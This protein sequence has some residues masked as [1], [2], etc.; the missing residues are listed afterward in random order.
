MNNIKE[1]LQFKLLRELKQLLVER[2]KGFA[3]LF[4]DQNFQK[5]RKGN[6]VSNQTIFYWEK[7]PWN[8]IDLRL[9]SS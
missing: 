2:E 7:I 8:A 5:V 9:E 6:M 4:W 1:L 3:I